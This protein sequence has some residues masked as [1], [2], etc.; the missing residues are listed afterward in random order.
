MTF[1]FGEKHLLGLGGKARRGLGTAH[2]KATPLSCF[3]CLFLTLFTFF[4]F[5]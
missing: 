5:V 4:V 1:Y 2:L 3:S